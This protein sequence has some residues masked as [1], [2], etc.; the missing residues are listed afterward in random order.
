MNV[1]VLLFVAVPLFLAGYYLYGRYLD[2]TFGM[3]DTRPTPALALND[4]TDYVPTKPLVAFSHHFASIAGAGPIIGPTVALMYGYMPAW[5]WIIIGGIFLGAVH[6]YTALFVS[7]REKG[8]SMAEVS[9][10]LLG[11]V[12]FWLF[13]GFTIA[14]IVLVTSA[15]LGLTATALSSLVPVADLKID[16]NSSV[17]KVVT[18]NGVQMG[19][20]GGI[21]STSVIVMTSMAPI[22]G[23]LM[24]KRNVSTWVGAS[25]ALVVGVISILIGLSAP[26]TLNPKVWM[27]IISLYTLVAAGVPV[28]VLLQ[29]RD[30]TNSFILYLGI[31]M[32][33]IGLLGGAASGVELQAPAWNVALGTAKMGPIWPFL[34]ITIACGA[35]SGFHNLVAAGTVSK[36]V[37]KER[38]ARPIGYGGMLL[39]SLLAV[40]VLLAVAGGLNFDL[41]QNIVYPTAAGAKSNP[42]LAFA[43][44]M[45]N[46]LHNAIGVPVAFGTVFGILMTEGFVVTTLDTAVRLNRY[47]F[48]E[49]WS[50]A[51]RGKAP[52]FLKSYLFNA[53]LSVAVMFYLGYTNKFLTIWPI[54]GSANQLLAAL[55]LIAVTVWLAYRKKANWFTLVPAIFMLGTTLV[56]LYQL[57]VTKYLPSGNWPLVITD[58]VLIV[59]SI[60]VTILAT[61]KLLELARGKSGGGEPARELSP[62]GD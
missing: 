7:M 8:K 22:I 24:Y 1:S 21:A 34:F 12:G 4:G 61:K 14:M 27:V 59:M 13:I 38:Y 49:L 35:I 10:R 29:P 28:W 19:Q 57:L 58:I 2:R 43:L 41:Y 37:T 56:A 11:R 33:V 15:F 60:G 20:I 32:L 3:D 30:F 9:S 51:F 36:Q 46:M 45:G 48:E 47:L 44:G 18:V 31:A 5:L 23:W 25:L 52:A 62:S 55:S 39:E 26:V 50:V 40:V 53:G 6:D 17:L 54:F 16:P 42:M